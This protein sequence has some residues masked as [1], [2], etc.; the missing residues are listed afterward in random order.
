MSKW[1]PITKELP[2][3]GGIYLVTLNNANTDFCEFDVS[4]KKWG[5]LGEICDE[6]TAWMPLP[7]PYKSEVE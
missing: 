6:V 3:Y 1:I 5:W 4:N 2:K 7:K